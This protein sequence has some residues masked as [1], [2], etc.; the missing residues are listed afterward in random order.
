M[1]V[2]GVKI[3][4]TFFDDGIYIII[5]EKRK[6]GLNIKITFVSTKYNKLECVL[7]FRSSSHF[8]GVHTSTKVIMYIDIN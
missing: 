6:G 7:F 2:S 4:N 1:C 3:D 8:I 5:L